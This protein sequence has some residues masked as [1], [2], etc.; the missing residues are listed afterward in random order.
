MIIE[1]AYVGVYT[2]F[3]TFDDLFA[4]QELAKRFNVPTPFTPGSTITTQSI[5]KDTMLSAVG[6][7]VVRVNINDCTLTPEQ[8]AMVQYPSFVK[9]ESGI[10]ATSGGGGSCLRTAS[11]AYDEADLRAKLPFFCFDVVVDLAHAQVTHDNVPLI[12]PFLIGAEL[13]AVAVVQHGRLIALDYGQASV[14]C[15]DKFVAAMPPSFPDGSTLD[16]FARAKC[17]HVV[18][19]A[20]TAVG[21]HNRILGVQLMYDWTKK[22]CRLIEI[23]LRTHVANCEHDPQQQALM[24]WQH[25]YSTGLAAFLLVTGGDVREAFLQSDAATTPPAVHRL[26]VCTKDAYARCHSYSF[27]VCYNDLE[28]KCEEREEL[29]IASDN[30]DVTVQWRD[31]GCASEATV[32]Q[33]YRLSVDTY[34][35]C[36]K[37]NPIDF[38]SHRG[39]QRKFADQWQ[40]MFINA[41]IDLKPKSKVH[42]EL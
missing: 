35:Q 9:H 21:V 15:D 19:T 22:E 27:V 10:S 11:V 16:A 20:V 30:D 39:N 26:F 13:T 38:R 6:Q 8:W 34:Q 41:K 7:N 29:A 3:D 17:E 2:R 14:R 42:S 23:N 36:L 1:G 33:S 4:H 5:S 12:T 37:E 31:T 28:P 24:G 32:D 18:E 40:E 25:R